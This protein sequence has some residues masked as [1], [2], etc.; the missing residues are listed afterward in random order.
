MDLNNGQLDCR[1]N[2]TIKKVNC[3]TIF[4]TSIYKPILAVKTD[5]DLRSN[6]R[7][8]VRRFMLSI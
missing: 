6:S 3:F 7:G 1:Q 8:G 4:S 5:F 2:L